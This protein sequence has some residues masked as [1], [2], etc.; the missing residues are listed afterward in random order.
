MLIAPLSVVRFIGFRNPVPFEATIFV[1]CFYA[2]AG[3]V[4]VVLFYWA[5]PAFGVS[6]S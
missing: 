1:G 5:R 3:L 4:D 2:F 6:S